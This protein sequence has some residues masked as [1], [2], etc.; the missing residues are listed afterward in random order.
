M[1]VFPVVQRA[2]LLFLFGAAWGACNPD[3]NTPEKLEYARILAIAADPP[4]PA[5]GAGTRLQPLVYVP[6]GEAIGLSWSWC[7]LPTVPDDDYACHVDQASADILFANLG[8][9]APPLDLGTAESAAWINPFPPAT[10]AA[11]CASGAS[12]SPIPFPCGSTGLPITIRLVVHSARGDLPAITNLYVPT[13]PGAAPNQNPVIHGLALGASGQLLDST[14]QFGVARG[15]GVPLHALV[16][17]SSAEPL[18]SPDAKPFERL[19]FSWLVEGGD[20]GSDGQGGARTG[21]LGDP[22]DPESPFAA[23]LD[24]TWNTPGMAE[25]PRETARIVVVVR[26]SRGGVAWTQ[27]Q[28]RLESTP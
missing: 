28:A 14:G 13:D 4:Q 5:T 1:N 8:V 16:D 26:D 20:F 2:C 10:A 18:A 27:G 11:L 24:N 6:D 19:S 7:P 25:Y 15:V 9:V 3:F 12:I 22:A 17:E 23:A 21:Y